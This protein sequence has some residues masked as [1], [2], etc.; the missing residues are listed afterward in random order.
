V[1]EHL[2]GLVRSGLV[3]AKI[4]KPMLPIDKLPSSTYLLDADDRRIDVDTL[5]LAGRP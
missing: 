3:G 4:I 2:K 1:L 5:L